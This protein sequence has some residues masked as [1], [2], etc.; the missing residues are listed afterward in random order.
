MTNR[1]DDQLRPYGLRTEQ[2]H[3]PLGIDEPTPRLSWK[4][5]CDRRGA[6]Q[7]AYRGRRRRGAELV[8]D[9]AAAAR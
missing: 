8:R 6:G 5:A 1:S 4:L 9:G 2:R 7:S 3:E